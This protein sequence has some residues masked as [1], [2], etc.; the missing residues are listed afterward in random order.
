LISAC[1]QGIEDALQTGYLQ[2]YPL[3]G[4]TVILTDATYHPQDSTEV[5][6]RFAAHRAVEQGFAKAQPA[7]LEPIMTLAIET[8]EEFVGPI[9][10]KLLARRA[11]LLG[12][13]IRNQDVV[14]HAE[15]PLAEMFGYAT[16]VRSLSHGMATFS[17]EFAT[18]R[19]MQPEA[20]LAKR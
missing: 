13:D 9:Q 12:S 18:Y 10:G 3:V 7:L 15:A 16:E 1:Q 19:P 17:M 20:A 5:A 4:V 8:P 11:I 14:I 6:F 2:G